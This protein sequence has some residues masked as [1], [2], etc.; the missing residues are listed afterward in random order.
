MNHPNPCFLLVD[1]HA[2]FRAG[3]VMLLQQGWPQARVCQAASW[4]EAQQMLALVQPALVLLDIHL[5]DSRGLSALLDL[6]A[7]WP[8]CPVVLMSSDVSA[9]L[10]SQAREAGAMG[11]LPK[12]A[13]PTE[14]LGGVRAALTGELAFGAVPYGALTS[15]PARGHAST[16]HALQA[17]DPGV[18]LTEAQK[19]ILSYLGRGT[20]N[21]AIARQVGL[22]E[23]QV[24]AEVSWLTEALGASSREEAFRK[25]VD[26]GWVAT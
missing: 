4:L 9:E 17:R 14:V 8:A 1:D 18:Q 2:L 5:P 23:M 21:K 3:L 13:S 20:P 11:F 26:L 25:A 22:S 7:R 24:R 19:R 6:R 15:V 12:S 10:V 16:P